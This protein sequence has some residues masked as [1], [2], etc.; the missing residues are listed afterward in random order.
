MKP[1]AGFVPA[2]SRGFPVMNTKPRPEIAE[3]RPK[4]SVIGVGGGGG[5]AVNNMISKSLEGAEF[6]VANTDAQALSM[7]KAS[8]LIQLG[9]HVTEGLGAGSLPEVGQAAAVESIDEIMDHLSGTHMCFVTAG[10]GGG[11]GTGAAP[12]IA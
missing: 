10:M 3:M 9:V 11:T 5:N 1:T 2:S 12:V 8:R 4:I 7:S 6:I